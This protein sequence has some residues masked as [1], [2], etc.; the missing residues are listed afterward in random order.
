[1]IGPTRD[2]LVRNL[3]CY[4][5]PSLLEIGSPSYVKLIFRLSKE[6]HLEIPSKSNWQKEKECL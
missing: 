1:L 3:L 6:L 2:P 4:I 5:D